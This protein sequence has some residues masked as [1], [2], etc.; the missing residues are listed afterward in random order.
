[1]NLTS[2]VVDQ[3]ERVDVAISALTPS[4]TKF[5]CPNGIQVDATGRATSMMTNSSFWTITTLDDGPQTVTVESAPSASKVVS[6][7]LAF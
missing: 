4:T 7:S 1:M 5:P 3:T 2:T 6:I